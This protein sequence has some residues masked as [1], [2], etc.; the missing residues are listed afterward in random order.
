MSE[1][2]IGKT[3]IENFLLIRKA[4]VDFSNRGLVGVFGPNGVG[5]SSLIMETLLYGLFGI[6]E[7][8]GTE[9][10]KVVN[11]FVGKDM[12][13]HIPLK[14]GYPDNQMDVEVD[15]FR[16]HTKYKDEVFLKINGEDR[17]G[18]TNA[19]TWEKISKLLDMDHT[20]FCNCVVFGQSMAQ[21]FSGLSDAQQKGIVE[22]LLGMSW[23][24]VASELSIRDRDKIDKRLD[25]LAGRHE[26]LKK[27][28]R[29]V[30]EQ[31]SFYKEKLKK[32]E[33][34]RVSKLKGLEGSFQKME[35]TS[36]LRFKIKELED[37]ISTDEGLLSDKKKLEDVLKDLDLE[38]RG[39]DVKIENVTAEIKKVKELDEKLEEL[40]DTKKTET[41]L[42]KLEESL[43]QAEDLLI[44][45][46]DVENTIKELDLEIRELFVKIKLKKEKIQEI[47][48]TISNLQNLSWKDGEKISCSSC[49]QTITIESKKQYLVHLTEDLHKL[50]EEMEGLAKELTG[51][52]T[53][54]DPV[55]ECLDGLLETETETK[56]LS[57][58]VAKCKKLLS[59]IQLRNAKIEEKNKNTKKL[60]KEA[61][62]NLLKL[63]KELSLLSDEKS[64]LLKSQV[65]PNKDLSVLLRIEENKKNYVK[66]LDS[67]NKDLSDTKVQNAKIEEKNS[68]LK[69]R[70]EEVKSETNTF[71]EII[72]KWE[73]KGKELASEFSDLVSTYKVLEQEEKY[74]GALVEVYSNR[75]F[76]SFVIESVLPDMDRFAAVYS[77]VMGGKYEIS[78]SPQTPTKKGEVREKFSVNV[79]NRFGAA[80]YNGNSS[81]EKRAVDSI[82][83]FVLGDLAASRLNNRISLLIL[84]D[85]F[86]KLDN[87]TCDSVI[88]ILHTMVFPKGMRDAE[89]K[90]LPE[91]ESI[92]VLTH[93]EQF[94]NSFENKIRVGRNEN[95]ETT[96]YR[97]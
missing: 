21:Y 29:E 51:V 59:D 11:R 5:K 93:L 77:Q 60:R 66:E 75:G 4:S 47:G 27:K 42:A 67:L 14:I 92:F 68:G 96:I 48:L 43:S 3:N 23:V 97:E 17:R 9:R 85:V 2:R 8:F 44:G 52:Q 31:L 45:K 56:K 39:V 28:I 10:D 80:D 37:K 94:K 91:R 95:G 18:K 36:E 72:E 79:V 41:E 13:L 70:M 69:K 34:E 46:R 26:E 57:G 62:G 64:N 74:C 40:E 71:Q 58:D 49:G 89:Y 82:I 24:P 73:T 7:R 65:E 22:K 16:K 35:D 15:A 50:D 81:G 32:F 78:F 84:D 19:H 1:I 6:S 38:I 55:K 33:D 53:K 61:S 20:S 87:K 12:H 86:E 90:D 88:K 76:K 30:E 54:K 63:N 83:M 25:E